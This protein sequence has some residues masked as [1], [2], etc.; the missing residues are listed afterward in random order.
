MF[1]FLFWPC[2]LQ[3]LLSLFAEVHCWD[4]FQG[5]FMV[6]FYAADI[7]SAQKDRL[8]IVREYVMLVVREYNQVRA[9][10]AHVQQPAHTCSSCP[11]S[12][13]ISS[14]TA[15]LQF[16]NNNYLLRIAAV[17]RQEHG[18]VRSST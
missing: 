5:K 12:A 18:L 16:H 15:H 4:K 2:P 13:Q 17:C 1:T 3:G 10:G 8:R 9:A 6:P 14:H 7:V 11:F